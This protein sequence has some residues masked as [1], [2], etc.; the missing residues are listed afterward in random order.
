MSLATARDTFVTEQCKK[1][2]C[3][4]CPGQ[5]GPWACTHDCHGSPDG[6]E[7][8]A[9][10]AGSG[11]ES[12][13]SADHSA[14]VTSDTS[15][16]EPALADLDEAGAR[17]LTDRIRTAAEQTFRL[18]QEAHDRKAWA[19]LGYS[20]YVEYAAA[21]F[22]MA[23]S[24]AYQLIDQARVVD[25]LEEAAGDSTSVENLTEAAARDIKPVLP[26]VV[27]DVKEQVAAGAEP[28]E[29]VKK[30]VD[31]ARAAKPKPVAER[32]Q[33]T[34]CPVELIGD[35]PP[36]LQAQ[37]DICTAPKESFSF[38]ESD[39]ASKK[40]LRAMLAG[41]I[42][43]FVMPG[44]VG[45]HVLE[46]LAAKVGRVLVHEQFDL[47]EPYRVWLEPGTTVVDETD[48]QR[49]AAEKAKRE[50]AAA[51]QANDDQRMAFIR[52]LVWKPVPPSVHDLALRTILLNTY[53]PMVDLVIEW[54]DIEPRDFDAECASDALFA[55]SDLLPDHALRGL[56]AT[57]IAACEPILAG[58]HDFG[59]RGSDR[60]LVQAYLAH[61][62]GEGYE[63]T[64]ID[65]EALSE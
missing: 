62:E 30:A 28:A 42:G 24:R 57:C 46:P 8:G 11:H 6:G 59:L 18:L 20:S 16:G 60:E 34:R 48:A 50:K 53:D 13:P 21:E 9:I 19:A 25:A 39:K 38:V 63:V 27:E 26:D 7:R 5:K 52:E 10:D 45:T 54:L 2:R 35:L 32:K 61:L 51:R 4:K 44:N 55:W 29:A 49:R 56:W 14:V 31:K 65:R 1:D 23:K 17:E 58:V 40:L 64:D 43:S 41:K 36:G 15:V 12:A 33:R 3:A 47:F 37:Q 22:G